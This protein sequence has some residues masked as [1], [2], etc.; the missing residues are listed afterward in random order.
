MKHAARHFVPL[1][2]MIV[3]LA[4]VC[5][6]GCGRRPAPEAQANQPPDLLIDLGNATAVQLVW[7]KSLRLYVGQ[8][9][10]SNQIYRRFHP[11]HDS[12]RYQ[13]LDLN[14]DNQPVVNVSWNEAQQFCRWLTENHGVSA[15]GQYRFRLPTEMEWETFA[16]SGRATEYPWGPDWPPPKKWNYFGRENPEQAQKL[17]RDDTFRVSCPVAESGKNAW[18]LFGVGG[19]VWEWCADPL[20]PASK[21]RVFKGASWSDCHPY[22]LKLSRRSSNAADSRYVNRGFRIVAENHPSGGQ[23][24][25]RPESD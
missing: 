25:D 6:A 19:N 5:P 15:A 11:E 17:D 3:A 9:E 22:F 12:G 13:D 16:S 1:A 7:I 23:E 21:S 8:Y 2:G 20:E 14:Q 10:I 4:A 18:N 24:A